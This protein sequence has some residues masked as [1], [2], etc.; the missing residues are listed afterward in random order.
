MLIGVRVTAAKPKSAVDKQTLRQAETLVDQA[1]KA[2]KDKKFDES[3]KLFMQ[4]YGLS[5]EP[6]LVFNAAR[7]YEEATKA[8]DAAALF[9]LYGTI[10][11]D[12]AGLA[13]AQAR[14]ARLEAPAPAQSPATPRPDAGN[15]KPQLLAP[16]ST[17]APHSAQA[18]P[19]PP[20]APA[21]VPA[22][23]TSTPPSVPVTTAVA[24]PN[25]TGPDR[26]WAWLTTATSFAL[27]G[28]GAA[29]MVLG[30]SASHDANALP[31][32]TDADRARY[33]SD[34]D[35]A[36]RTWTTGAALVAVGVVTGGA[37]A[38]LHLRSGS[39]VAAGLDGSGGIWIAGRW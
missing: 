32:A 10:S 11:R 20:N 38:W 8:G 29:M 37:A 14:L 17:E 34:F 15:A 30:A 2:F 33:N 3:A 18:Q 26:M 35:R 19:S 39:Q 28:S 16:L 23:Q 4:A 24:R 25:P 31:I 7:A 27:V 22:A 5:Q 6:A 13:D 12:P 36:E 1:K 9:R 21:P